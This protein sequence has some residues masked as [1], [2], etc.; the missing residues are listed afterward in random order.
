MA[1]I[2]LFSLEISSSHVDYRLEFLIVRFQKNEGALTHS[3]IQP[4]IG[5]L[6]SP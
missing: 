4:D 6:F 2:P 1:Q 5:P 3:E